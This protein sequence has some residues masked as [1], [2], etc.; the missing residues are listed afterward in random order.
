MPS[1]ALESWEPARVKSTE[2]NTNCNAAFETVSNYDWIKKRDKSTNC[3]GDAKRVLEAVLE[4]DHAHDDVKGNVA[5]VVTAR[6]EHHFYNRTLYLFLFNQY[7]Y[8]TKHK[9]YFI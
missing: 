3:R 7:L 4:G 9:L 6:H 2:Q 1:P 8:S 5:V